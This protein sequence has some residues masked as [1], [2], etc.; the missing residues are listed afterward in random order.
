MK[1]ARLTAVGVLS[2][3]ALFSFVGT[4]NAAGTPQ[5]AATYSSKGDVSFT[6]DN[7]S[8]PPLDPTN[9]DKDK[10]IQ[11]N[12]KDPVDPGTTGPL[13]IDRVSNI[14]FGEQ[15]VSSKDE[16]Y[17]AKPTEIILNDGTS[18]SAPNYVQLTDKRG[19]NVG[20]KLQVTQEDQFKTQDQKALEGAQ[21]TFAN[22]LTKK[23]ATN[24]AS[25]PTTQTPVVF[26]KFGQAKTIM[27]A[28]KGS[29]M[30]T[31][32]ENFGDSSNMDKSISLFV[33]GVSAKDQTGYSATF[34]WTLLDSPA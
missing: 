29:G 12:P 16:T 20:W 33:P 18:T 26:D 22:G 9:P 14:H 11:D 10:P 15:K 8:V 17:W 1:T 30:G 3:A 24:Q 4:A 27:T 32:F 23:E 2:A 7:S 28:T 21:V 19:T 13:T 25:A 34:T 6:L 31:W 5:T